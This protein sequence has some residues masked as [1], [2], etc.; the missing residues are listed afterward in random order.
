MKIIDVILALAIAVV[1]G[2]AVGRVVKNR[3]QGKSACGCD[4]AGCTCGCD[5]RKSEQTRQGAAQDR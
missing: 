1:V 2:L 3:R 4:C 5:R